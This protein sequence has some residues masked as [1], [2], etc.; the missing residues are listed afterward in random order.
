[1]IFAVRQVLSSKLSGDSTALAIK[2]PWNLIPIMWLYSEKYIRYPS[3]AA[4]S[5][6]ETLVVPKKKFTASAPLPSPANQSNSVIIIFCG[7]YTWEYE[8]FK[9]FT[10]RVSLIFPTES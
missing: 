7:V 3:S 8:P 4:S 10:A 1:M 9:V 2:T 6:P 5:A